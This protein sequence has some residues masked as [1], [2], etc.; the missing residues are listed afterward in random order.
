MNDAEF[1]EFL[2]ESLSEL[3]QKQDFFEN[4]IWLR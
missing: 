1:E 4:G 3:S 2:E